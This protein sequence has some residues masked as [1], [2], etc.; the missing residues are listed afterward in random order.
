MEGGKGE[1]RYREGGEGEKGYREGG[2]GEERYRE[3][4]GRGRRDTGNDGENA[5]L[6]EKIYQ[7]KEN[8]EDRKLQIKKKIKYIT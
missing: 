3:G 2:E 5:H 1:E 8:T 6:K 4:G 7:K